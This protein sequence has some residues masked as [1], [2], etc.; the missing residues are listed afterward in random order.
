MLHDPSMQHLFC[1]ARCYLS[2]ITKKQNDWPTEHACIRGFIPSRGTFFSRRFWLLS[3]AL[4]VELWRLVGM[5]NTIPLDQIDHIYVNIFTHKCFCTGTA[6]GMRGM[7][8]VL[9]CAVHLSRATTFKD[10]GS[11]VLYC[12]IAKLHTN[13][14]TPHKTVLSNPAKLPN[15]WQVQWLH[16]CGWPVWLAAHDL[17]LVAALES[18][19]HYI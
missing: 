12:S 8:T 4:G 13:W 6:S 18:Y 9:K 19:Y 2:S 16:N 14:G 11:I 3:T 17:K 7:W 15:I 10:T 5:L 1:Q